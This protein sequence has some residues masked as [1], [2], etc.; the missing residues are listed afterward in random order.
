M[1]S[2]NTKQTSPKVIAPKQFVRE[3]G[4]T[5]GERIEKVET[6]TDL[7]TD[8]KSAKSPINKKEKQQELEAL[9]KTLHSKPESAKRKLGKWRQKLNEYKAYPHKHHK[10]LPHIVCSRRLQHI[11]I[12]SC[13]LCKTICIFHCTTIT[14]NYHH[15]TII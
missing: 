4:F 11:D 8:I 9:L 2:T 15:P 10:C 12:I 6:W 14:F 13:E 1:A 7:Q 5:I 3:D